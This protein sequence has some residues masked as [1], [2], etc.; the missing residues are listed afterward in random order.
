MMRE[1]GVADTLVALTM[2]NGRPAGTRKS[3]KPRTSDSGAL[4]AT[5]SAALADTGAKAHPD[6]ARQGIPIF[7]SRKMPREEFRMSQQNDD[8]R[9]RKHD[10]SRR[11]FLVGAALGAA[12]G[13]VPE[14][15]AQTQDAHATTGAAPHTM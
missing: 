3:S 8:K 4:H 5:R 9:D 13:I 15:Q 6:R 2:P 10:D 14:A 1:G 12:A 11:A 7:P